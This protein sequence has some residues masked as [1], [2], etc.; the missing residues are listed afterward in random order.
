[1]DCSSP[2]LLSAWNVEAMVTRFLKKEDDDGSLDRD[3]KI[4]LRECFIRTKKK[5]GEI[6][7][8]LFY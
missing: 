4:S 5:E 1:M 3:P 2:R 8:V 7:G 6:M